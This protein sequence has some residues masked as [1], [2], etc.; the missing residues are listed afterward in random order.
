MRNVA[1]ERLG[2]HVLLLD[3]QG[4]QIKIADPAGA[5]VVEMKIQA[6]EEA[7]TLGGVKGHAWVATASRWERLREAEALRAAMN[8]SRVARQS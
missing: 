2:S 6:I 3:R 4:D 8:T 5:G 1:I 7:M